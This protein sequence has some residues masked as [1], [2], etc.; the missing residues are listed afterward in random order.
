MPLLRSLVI[1]YQNSQSLSFV[2]LS[3]R[4]NHTMVATASTL[5]LRHGVL[6]V[7]PL[8]C[9]LTDDFLAEP[10]RV[11]WLEVGG[12]FNDNIRHG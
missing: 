1:R 8:A 2:I 12:D 7:A 10:M 11:L 5:H 4:V 9:F 3:L 6:R